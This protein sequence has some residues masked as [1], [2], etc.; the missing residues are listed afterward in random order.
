[1]RLLFENV[2]LRKIKTFIDYKIKIFIIFII[3]QNDVINV[4]CIKFKIIKKLNNLSLNI[5]K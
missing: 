3:H 5:L 1:M 2:E 4:F